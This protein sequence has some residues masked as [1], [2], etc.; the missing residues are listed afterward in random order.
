MFAGTYATE[1]GKSFNM[2]FITPKGG[3]DMPPR[4]DLQASRQE[5]IP[6]V[7][8]MVLP[9]TRSSYLTCKI[10]DRGTLVSKKVHRMSTPVVVIG[11]IL[12]IPC[13]CGIVFCGLV[14]AALVSNRD[15]NAVTM[16]IPFGIAVC[17]FVSG[18]LGWLL[19]MKKRVLK[20]TFCG[21]VVETG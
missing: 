7:R 9:Q 1:E 18:L 16:G 19:V 14:M 8:Y 3:W 5:V 17:L 21:A 11:Y 13:I 2:S 6:P 20:C 4:Q 15:A 12:L 10:C